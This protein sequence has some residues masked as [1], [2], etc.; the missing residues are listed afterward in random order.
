[1]FNNSINFLNLIKTKMIRKSV[2]PNDL[3]YYGEKDPSYNGGYKP[4]AISGKDFIA[5]LLE[6]HTIIGQQG[7]IGPQGVPGPVGP[8][9]LTWQGVWVS[10]TTYAID[11]AVGY[12]GASW[13]CIAP[14]SGTTPPNL[15]T[16]EWALLAAQGATGPQGPQGIAGPAGPSGSGLSGT[17]YG[18]TTYWDS[19]SAQWKPTGGLMTNPGTGAQGTARVSIGTNQV[20]QTGYALR[21]FTNNAGMRIDQI[22]PGFG[23]SNW[24][25][26]NATASQ[27]GL[28]GSTADPLS[29]YAFYFTNFNN[30]AFK[31][32][33]NVNGGGGDRFLIQGNGQ[34]TVG[35]ALATNTDANFVVKT[36][37]IEVEE[38]GKGIILTSPDGTRYR[39][40]VSNGGVIAASAV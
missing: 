30:Y 27:Y 26:N 39:I 38:I 22:T 17:S 16:T 6:N 3:I 23:I 21:M 36:K 8:A 29:N 12:N 35:S 20:N 33:T 14:T 34:V 10:G 32:A 19:Y 2:Q 4:V 15:A 24:L 40:R 25:S 18:Q 11:D 37:D 1:M 5:D 7:P 9:G 13:F 28:N 31:F